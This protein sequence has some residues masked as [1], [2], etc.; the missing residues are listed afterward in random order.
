VA[1]EDE[2]DEAVMEGCSLEHERRQRGD[3]TTAKS[4]GGSSSVRER[5][6]A[7]ESLEVRGKVR[8]LYWWCLP[9]YRGRGSTG[10]AAT[11]GNDWS[12]GLQAID[13]RGRVKRG[14]KRGIQGG[15]GQMLD[16]HHEAR[17]HGSGD[18]RGRWDLVV[19]Q[20]E[21]E[22]ANMRDPHGSGTRENASLWNA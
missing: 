10:E 9:C 4:S 6:R 16:R 21:E 5:R 17:D 8:G 14:F 12:N 7:R 3:M 15:G 2:Q 19:A 1:E 18:G 22:R 20:E 13:G 11:G